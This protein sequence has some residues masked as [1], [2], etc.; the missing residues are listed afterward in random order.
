[1]LIK[2]TLEVSLY[3]THVSLLIFDLGNICNNNNNTCNNNNNNNNTKLFRVAVDEHLATCFLA[4]L[5]IE[6]AW[7]YDACLIKHDTPGV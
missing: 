6:Q 3:A 7:V 1:M 5:K 2:I 4:H